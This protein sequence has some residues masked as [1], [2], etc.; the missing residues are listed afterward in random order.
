[1]A[2]HLAEHAIVQAAHV[3]LSNA[4]SCHPSDP[5]IEATT[6]CLALLAPKSSAAQLQ[7]D[8]VSGLAR[9][10]SLGAAPDPV[11]WRDRL[12]KAR[13]RSAPAGS[14]GAARM[15]PAASAASSV[16]LQVCSY[17]YHVCIRL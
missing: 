10:A 14:S 4:A 2:P 17:Q 9:A 12:A 3:M 13:E 16:D 11:E 7:L 6:R 1:M 15:Q 5:Y 8:T